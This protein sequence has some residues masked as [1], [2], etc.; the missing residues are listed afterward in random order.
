MEHAM[1]APLA[2]TI[3]EVRAAVGDQ[4]GQGSVLV[5]IHPPEAA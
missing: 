1:V 5:T 3:V 2:G 4:V